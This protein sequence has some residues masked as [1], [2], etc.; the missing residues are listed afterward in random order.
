MCSLQSKFS[1]VEGFDPSHTDISMPAPST[2]ISGST[3]LVQ[4]KTKHD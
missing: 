1:E 3:S 4:Y 2:G